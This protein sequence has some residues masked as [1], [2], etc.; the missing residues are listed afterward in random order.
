MT[1]TLKKFDDL[2]LLELYSLLQL[3]NEVF[4]IEQN[5]VYADLDN[6]DQTSWHL[7]GHREN[8]LVAYTRILPPGISY[9]D[10]ASIG[11][12]ITASSA[13]NEGLGKELMLRSIDACKNLF[14][15]VPITLS[16]QLYLKRFY[17]S[18]GFIAMGPVYQEDGIDH[19]KMTR[20]FSS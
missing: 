7:M 14:G 9:P 3:R 10:A 4:I 13:R 1:W 20:N 17:T 15:P 5:C 2:T 6:K 8:R 18:L 12:V 11:R 16:A 19:I